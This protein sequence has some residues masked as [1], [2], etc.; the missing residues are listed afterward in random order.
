MAANGEDGVLAEVVAVSEGFCAESVHRLSHIT[1]DVIRAQMSPTIKQARRPLAILAMANGDESMTASENAVIQR[2]C[3]DFSLLLSPKFTTG[4]TFGAAGVLAI[5][6][7][8]QLLAQ[9]RSIAAC[10]VNDGQV[11]G[12]V[13]SV[14]LHQHYE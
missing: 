10:I 11:G 2:E 5:G 8:A 13:S 6:V 1:F 4:E 9:Q 14:L 12:S 3:P 7:G